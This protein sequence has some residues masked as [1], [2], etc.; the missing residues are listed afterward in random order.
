MDWLRERLS[1]VTRRWEDV[2][3]KDKVNE[4]WSGVKG[5]E[6]WKTTPESFDGAYG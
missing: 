3:K 6:A 5:R 4:R 1:P 2:K